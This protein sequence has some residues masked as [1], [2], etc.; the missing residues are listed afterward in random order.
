MTEGRTQQ[1]TS[2]E[3]TGGKGFNYEDQIVAYY[4]AALLLEGHAA[5]CAGVVTSVAL[6]QAAVHPMDDLVVEVRDVAGTRVLGLQIKRSLRLTSAAS[7]T[8]F[9]QTM[10]AA[11]KTRRLSSFRVGRDAYGFVTEHVAV[12]SYRA[13]NRLIDWARSDVSGADF[14]NRFEDGGSAAAAER[15]MRLDLRP[16]TEAATVDA[17]IDFYQHLVALRIDGLGEDG[18]TRGAIITQLKGIVDSDER[19]L[20]ELLFNRL[21]QI[22]SDGAGEG[23]TWARLTLVQQLRG[24]VPL[25]CS[26]SYVDDLD[27]IRRYS[28]GGMEDILDEISGCHVA[29]SGLL[30][31]ISAQ[32]QTFR[33]VNLTG[34]PGCGKSAALKQFAKAALANGT[35]L[36][37]KSDRLFGNSWSAFSAALGLRH[38]AEEILAEI[39]SV[40]TPVLFIDGIDRIPLD[41]RGVIIDLLRVIETDPALGHWKVLATSRDQGLEP[42]RA[43]FPHSFYH[44][45]GIG[46][47]L[48]QP[49]SDIEAEELATQVPALRS[50]LGH[51]S[52]V[53]E[54]ARR[55]FF[56][57]VLARDGA[58][59]KGAAPQTEV[60][61]IAAWWSRAGYDASADSAELRRRAL[62]DLAEKG[63]A[64]LGKSIR[65]RGLEPNTVAQLAPLRADLIVRDHD[66]GAGVSFTHDIFFEWA[67]YRLLIDLGPDWHTA[68]IGAGEPPLL[69]RIV[70]LLAQRSLITPSRWVQEYRRLETN[71]LRAQWRR[72]W[73]T[74][75][76]FSA[77]FSKAAVQ[78]EFT[79]AMHQGD[80]QLLKKLLVWFQAEYTVPNP[81][82]LARAATSEKGDDSIRV[83]HLLG[84]PSDVRSWGRL[85]DWL[86]QTAE[87]LP[88]QLIPSAVEVFEVWLNMW[89]NQPI[90]RTGNIVS[91]C[92][93]WLLRLEN[94][95]GAQSSDRLWNSLGREALSQLAASLRRAIMRSAVAYPDAAVQLYAR[96]VREKYLEDDA[97]AMLMAYTHVMAKIDPAIVVAL[98]R[99]T[100][101][102]E[103]PGD[104]YSREREEAR[105]YSE[106]RNAI[107]AIPEEDRTPE[108]QRSLDHM[109]YSLGQQLPD[110]DDIGIKKFHP[111][112]VDPSSQ[113]E[114]FAS[115]FL[116]APDHAIGLVGAMSNHAIAGWRQ[117]HSIRNDLRTPSP[118]AVAFPWGAQTFWGD[119]PIYSWSQGHLG[120][121]PIECA[122]LALSYW[123][124]QQVEK[125]QAVD[126]IIR[127]IVEQSDCVAALGLALMIALET[128]H[129]SET[130]LA[131]VTCQRLWHYDLKRVIQAPTMD[132]DLFGKHLESRHT[133]DKAKAQAFLKGRKSQRRTVRQLA[134]A[135]AVTSDEPLRKRFQCD[136]AAFPTDL[137]FEFEED[138]NNSATVQRLTELAMQW[139]GQGDS[140]NYR[141]VPMASGRTQ[142]S[143]ESPVPLDSAQQARLEE[144][145]EFLHASRML[146]WAAG[147]L[148]ANA[149]QADLTL[150]DAV[151]YAKQQDD[152]EM[153]QARQDVGD[154]A[155]QSAISGVAACVILF[156]SSDDPNLD[157]A[158]KVMERVLNM[159][160]RFLNGS[161]VPWHPFNHLVAALVHQ[162]TLE[163]HDVDALMILVEFTQ[164][165]LEGIST[166]AFAGL[167]RDRDIAVSW[168][169]GQLA[170][171]TAI[172]WRSSWTPE[173]GHNHTADRR[174]H[175]QSLLLAK[176]AL[177]DPQPTPLPDMP[178]PWVEVMRLA[179]EGEDDP[180]LRDADPFFD[181]H[182]AAKVF[183]FFPVECW[184]ASGVYQNHWQTAIAGFANWT[185]SRLMPPRA[186]GR[187]S[188]HPEEYDW[189]L[190]L[191]HLFART[192]PF[193]DAR[194]FSDIC[195]VPY[196]VPERNALQMLSRIAQSLAC[197]HVLDAADIPANA[198]SFLEKCADR[199]IADRAF[200][201][202]RDGSVHDSGLSRLIDAVLF[203]EVE[204]APGASRFANGDWSQ[205][206]IVMPLVTTVMT[207]IGWAP[208]VMGKFLTL[209][210]RAS[211]SY[212]LDAFI[213]QVSTALENIELAQGA[214]IGSTLPARIAA[215]VQH[216]ADV[217]FPLELEQSLGLL[218]ILD[219]LIDLGDRRS[220]ALEQSEVFRE[221]RRFH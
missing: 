82:I 70:G 126:A 152:E 103:L 25:R 166:A 115:L 28:G 135:F 116:H 79:A 181:W 111:Y 202:Q 125:G 84:W 197:R 67:F 204:H 34:L 66:D 182:F 32:L 51:S 179:E 133:E 150:E 108:Q 193:V 39:G 75:P 214:W 83:A 206:H 216:F 3:L 101:L 189:H 74:A 159:E 11:A 42:Y 127:T 220:A 98:A 41:R 164:H 192:A 58:S 44:S 141:A 207:S 148:Q 24:S 205:I 143:Y 123:A 107:R 188:R 30:E 113:H 163:E 187:K 86:L 89:A 215:L 109:F 114:P 104:C 54:I 144:A 118:V 145:T 106:R 57:A 158:W 121:G 4:L 165:P 175:E 122:F 46:D 132:L 80:F 217:H 36:F 78:A 174:S 120:P 72:A 37:L 119:W 128:L 26:P 172:R 53:K 139:S 43:W 156:G 12:K 137:P 162:R 22:A 60:D 68:I 213:H 7:N 64:E 27:L 153:F 13:I 15:A 56:A 196:T 221:V 69:G 45:Q 129:V 21:C 146:D 142:I 23:R 5:G 85:I 29:R 17:E 200:S 1:S 40:G 94:A 10:A 16:L 92:S 180:V 62:I 76:P 20:P 77:S 157:W 87:T 71:S 105:L 131:L 9:L 138:A 59:A 170:M 8:D 38:T 218:R 183:K 110:T 134:M 93:R 65:L 63:V 73:L 49:F 186:A 219:A 140:D 210:E 199:L 212:P 151:A 31:K 81:M 201:Q 95:S 19:G 155:V 130:T 194:W 112:Y 169:A 184:C 61:L 18:L 176:E 14:A 50:L 161:Q 2:T 154:H 190:T 91:Q 195:I 171:R 90:E 147:S 88:G 208:Y 211:R 52:A 191:G 198:L 203:V 178:A 149:L 35:C 177:V 96:A 167:L 160:E 47:V 97:Y 55:P 48:V 168:I 6:Q 124:F 102:E 33:L 209:C 117:V 136:L 99:A 185:T 100:L 173:G